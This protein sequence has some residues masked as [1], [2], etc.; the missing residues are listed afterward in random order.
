MQVREIQVRS[1][2]TRTGGFLRRGYSHTVNPYGGC[3]FGGALCGMPCYAQHN[4]WVTQGRAWGSFLDVKVNAAGLYREQAPRERRW[5]SRRGGLRIYMSSVT[6]PYVPQERSYRITRGLLEAMLDLPPDRLVLQTH[7]PYPLWDLE[8]LR[9]LARRVAD[10]CV[11]ISVETDREQ[12]GDGFPPHATPLGERIEALGRLRQAGIRTV[13]VVAPMLPIDDPG[14]FARR[15]GEAADRVLLD[16][17]LLGDGSPNGLRT[18]RT[19][20]PARLEAA[21][22]SAWTSLDRFEEICATFRDVLGSE[23]V[24]VSCEGFNAPGPGCASPV[25]SR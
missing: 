18:Q 7:T 25:A 12:M 10:L 3:A 1:I 14:A 8:A 19:G 4:T 9:A 2:L 5:A 22:L 21:G 17:F 23:R 20:F 16:H 11:N 13:A 24:L 15:L 6:D